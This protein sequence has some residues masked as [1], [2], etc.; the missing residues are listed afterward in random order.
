MRKVVL[1]QL[2]EKRITEIRNDDT[3]PSN[4]EGK[5][6]YQLYD[7]CVEVVPDDERQ[8]KHIDILE[9]LLDHGVEVRWKGVTCQEKWRMVS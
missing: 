3:I 8:S 1:D 5:K 6:P 7:F 9:Y 2:I 4:E